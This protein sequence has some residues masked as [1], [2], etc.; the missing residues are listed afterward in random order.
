MPLSAQVTAELSQASP[1]PFATR[2]RIAAGLSFD[3]L[4]Q[5]RLDGGIFFSMGGRPPPSRRTR[6]GGQIVQAILQFLSPAADRLQVHPGDL[7][8]QRV[9]AMPH[10]HGFQR[11]IPTPLLLV[12]TAEQQIHPTMDQP[13]PMIAAFSAGEALTNM[14]CCILHGE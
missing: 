8:Q 12:Q 9:S 14:N 11:H 13:L 6:S 4:A 5:V 1:H 3:Q 10:L 7:G 2:H